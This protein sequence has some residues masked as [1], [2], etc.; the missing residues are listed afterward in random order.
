MTIRYARWAAVST[1]D[2]ANRNKDKISI[3]MQLE[4]GADFAEANDWVET[5]GPFTVPGASLTRYLDLSRAAQDMPAVAQLWAAAERRRFDVLI[6]YSW[7]RLGDLGKMVKTLLDGFG[8]QIYSVLQPG[9]IRPPAEYDPYADQSAD[10]MLHSQEFVQAFRIADMRQK[11]KRYVPA[12]AVERGLHPTAPALYGYRY[13]SNKEPH[14]LDPV[15]GRV[16]VQM[17]DAFLGG[18]SYRDLARLAEGSGLP[19]PR[20]RAWDPSYIRMLM[21]NPFY[22]GLTVFGRTKTV[23]NPI[24]RRSTKIHQPR[25][26]WRVGAGRH[27][28]LWSVEDFERCWKEFHNRVDKHRRHRGRYQLSGLIFCEQHAKPVYRFRDDARGMKYCCWRH[29]AIKDVALYEK[30]VAELIQEMQGFQDEPA[31]EGQGVHFAASLE[32]LHVQ[33]KRILSLAERG[34]YSVEEAEQKIAAVKKEIEQVK[35]SSERE[36]QTAANRQTV[37]QMAEHV[38]DLAAWFY[39]EDPKIVNHTLAT[40]C[41]RITV[42]ANGKIQFYWREV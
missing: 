33:R 17:K 37:Q 8:I 29:F 2:Q 21:I 27:Q 22:A 35:S 18:A 15:V 23:F 20:G 28:A 24:T 6:I 26:E 10:I 16:L 5:A 41:E 4:T 39:N 13:T 1:K 36:V 9:Q 14:Q 40:I 12:R 34:L 32:E 30:V 19:A 42:D 3:E 38:D 7:D 31:P 25:G 11:F